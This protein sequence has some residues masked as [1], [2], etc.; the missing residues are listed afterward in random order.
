MDVT[1]TPRQSANQ[2]LIK[3]RNNGLGGKFAAEVM[4]IIRKEDG[5]SPISQPDWPM[6]WVSDAKRDG[7]AATVHIPKDQSRTLDLARC[8]QA[9]VQESHADKADEPHWLFHPFTNQSESC[10]GHRSSP[11]KTCQP[12]GSLY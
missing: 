12:G 3:V 7:S 1:L 5:Q 2:L 6:P 10:I 9:T 4:M 11:A 8:D